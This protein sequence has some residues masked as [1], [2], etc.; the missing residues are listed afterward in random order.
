MKQLTAQE[1]VYLR[2]QIDTG[3]RLIKEGNELIKKAAKQMKA[4]RNEQNQKISE[5]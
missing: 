2:A 5:G 1:W 4:E 3:L